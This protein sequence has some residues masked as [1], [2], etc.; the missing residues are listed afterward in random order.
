[1]KINTELGQIWVPFGQ[2][3]RMKSQTA[4]KMGGNYP[5]APPSRT[6]MEALVS[7][8][9]HKVRRSVAVA[10]ASHFVHIIFKINDISDV[11]K[12]YYGVE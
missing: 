11:N 6:P 10:S 5:P 2:N 3:A 1:M 8:D 12:A 4:R 7:F 9:C